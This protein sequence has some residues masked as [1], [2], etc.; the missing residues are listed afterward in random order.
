[1]ISSMKRIFTITGI[2]VVIVIVLAIVVV[3]FHLG[4]VIEAAVETAGPTFTGGPVT[5][6]KAFV[7]PFTGIAH[8]ESLVVGNPDG[9]KTPSAFEVDEV[10]MKLN[11]Q[12]LA[13]DTIIIE[14]ILIDGP[15]ITFEKSLRKSNIAKILDNVEEATASA[16][17]EHKSDTQEATGAAGNGKKV[18]IEHVLIKGSKV[19]LSTAILLGK[20]VSL[21]LPPVELNDIGKEEGGTSFGAAMGEIL[22][23]ILG[24][25][26]K[27]ASAAGKAAVGGAKVAG[28]A[29]VGAGAAAADGAKAI[30]E[31][32]GDAIKDV[33]KLLGGD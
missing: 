21:P 11:V 2:A 5:L 16:E 33:G 3:G 23:A 22:A 1:M 28:D 25:V 19:K 24:S 17:G 15:A 8:L 10:S 12:S 32:A 18:V 31:G 29:A 27:V 30:G 20:A 14:E 13:S 9:Y 6:E 4:G 26:T 7:R